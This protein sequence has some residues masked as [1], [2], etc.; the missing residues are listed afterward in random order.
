MSDAPAK[1]VVIGAGLVGTLNAIYFAQRGW[2]VTLYDMRGDLRLPE[3]K[4]KL[5]GKTIN[6]SLSER[7][8]SALRATGLGLEKTILETAVPMRGHRAQ[9]NATLLDVAE[10]MPNI[11]IQFNHQLI[12]SEMDIGVLEFRHNG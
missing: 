5:R 8:L 2:E 4:D 12:S 11:S 10:K 7:G 3:E 6:L 1:V 9:L